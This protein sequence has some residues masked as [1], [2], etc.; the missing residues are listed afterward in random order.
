MLENIDL[1]DIRDFLLRQQNKRYNDISYIRSRIAANI[2]DKKDFIA[3][4]NKD[5]GWYDRVIYI[6]ESLLQ[7]LK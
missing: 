3:R 5:D 1:A 6:Y 2:E 4:G 7:I